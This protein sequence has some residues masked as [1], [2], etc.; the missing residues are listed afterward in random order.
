MIFEKFLEQFNSSEALQQKVYKKY[1]KYLQEASLEPYQVELIKLQEHLE[2]ESEKMIVLVE[3]R[4]ASGKGGTIRRL[5]RYMNEKHYRVV[6][7][8][9]PSDVQRTQWYFQRY[10]EQFPHGGEIVLFDRSWYN[11]AMVEPVFNF[12]TQEQY[13]TF[14]KSVPSFEQDLIEHGTYF[15][16]IYFSVTKE[17]Q[18]NRFQERET[19]PLKQWKLSEIDVQMQERWDDFTQM[20]YR[21]LKQTHTEAAPWTVI[22][23]ND[24]FRAR[25]NAIK[26]I[27]NSVDYADRNPDL[28]Y[29]MDPE[30]VHSGADEIGIMEEDLRASG[31]FLG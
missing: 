17:E 30:V 9:K 29:A 11:R 21:M 22:R 19:N 14:M 4:D 7:L 1:T 18:S 24:K 12:C 28:D 25:L 10:V 8:G 20:K 27:L 3:G 16:K 6:A 2:K 31:K 23:S 26:T 15:I 13:E 5:T